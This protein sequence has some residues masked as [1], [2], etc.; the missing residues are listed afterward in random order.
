MN[1][2]NNPRKAVTCY[3]FINLELKKIFIVNHK[4]GISYFNHLFTKKFLGE[5]K[6]IDW[7]NTYQ[8]GNWNLALTREEIQNFTDQHDEREFRKMMITRNPYDRA[9]SFFTN[10]FWDNNGQKEMYIHT[11]KKMVG[12]RH[13]ELLGLKEAGKFKEAF[14]IFLDVQWTN[15]TEGAKDICSRNNG[16]GDE[17]IYPQSLAYKGL[18]TA[19]KFVDIKYSQS[20]HV[21][22][23]LEFREELKFVASN[24]SSNSVRVLED[25]FFDDLDLTAF[26]DFY[27]DDFELNSYPII[28]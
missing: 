2:V 8:L 16:L 25:G 9:L 20:E 22:S 4:C 6:Y 28:E 5:A 17:H 14:N 13:S 18:L 7:K 3:C 23:F 24:P 15:P 27:R 19:M 12:D 26:N 11:W 21:M 1:F 10:T